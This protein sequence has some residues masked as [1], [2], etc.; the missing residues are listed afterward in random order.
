MTSYTVGK[1]YLYADRNHNYAAGLPIGVNDNKET[2]MPDNTVEDLK[3]E[4]SLIYHRISGLDIDRATALLKHINNTH[5]KTVLKIEDKIL[6]GE[7]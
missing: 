1:N 6:R 2:D 5:E 7:L 4:I 3:T